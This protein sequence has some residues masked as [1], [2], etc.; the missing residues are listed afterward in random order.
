MLA[1]SLSTSTLASG[2]GDT[3]DDRPAKWSYISAVV[4]QPSCATANCHSALS[5]RSGVDLSDMRD[6]YD[7]LVGGSFVRRGQPEC[8]TL[9]N[10]LRGEGSRRMPPTF[11]LPSA[12]IAL[13]ERWIEAGAD[14]DGPGTPRIAVPPPTGPT[15]SAA[16]MVAPLDGGAGDAQ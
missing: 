2:C 1:L 15:C 4:I 8:S 11:P 10:L 5:D 12:D 16:G 14:Y 7:R 6:G 3:M 13:I 9:M